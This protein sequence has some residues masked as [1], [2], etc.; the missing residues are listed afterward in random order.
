M[1]DVRNGGRSF[2]S[3]LSTRVIA[4]HY[5]VGA[6]RAR[7]YAAGEQ[8]RISPPS[9]RWRKIG[10]RS[11]AG[12]GTTSSLGAS[13]R[14]EV[15]RRNVFLSGSPRKDGEGLPARRNQ[16]AA[17]PAGPLRAR[18]PSVPRTGSERAA[19]HS[20]AA[21][22]SRMASQAGWRSAQV[23]TWRSLATEIR[24]GNK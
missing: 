20:R 18:E 17:Q 10:G 11:G 4:G 6:R 21:R 19:A 14:P 7:V 13:R 15:S 2:R 3:N 23:K 12:G 22:S 5:P 8:D 24:C 9:S 16:G 1:G